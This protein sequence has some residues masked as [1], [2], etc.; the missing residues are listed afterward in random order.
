MWSVIFQGKKNMG[1]LFLVFLYSIG[2]MK[3]GDLT[4]KDS[5]KAMVQFSGVYNHF[6]KNYSLVK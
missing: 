3:F 6:V 5:V 1:T 4:S 2:E